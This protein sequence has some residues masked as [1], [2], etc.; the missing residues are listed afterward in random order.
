LVPTPSR[1]TQKLAKVSVAVQ[2]AAGSV[3]D[4]DTLVNVPA[5]PADAYPAQ[6]WLVTAAALAA[7]P[8]ATPDPAGPG[9]IV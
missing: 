1:P 3:Q 9:I 8:C 7:N 4:A 5:L 2:V 6:F